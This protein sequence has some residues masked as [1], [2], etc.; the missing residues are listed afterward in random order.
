MQLPKSWLT[1][2]GPEPSTAMEWAWASARIVVVFTAAI[3]ALLFLE[4]NPARPTILR[5]VG[6]VI[7]YDIAI[8]VLVKRG[9]NRAAFRIGFTLDHVVLLTVWWVTVQTT[10]NSAPN[11]L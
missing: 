9:F 10:D 3:G 11:D 1:V 5:A 2:R 7:L 8:V 4:G 6:F